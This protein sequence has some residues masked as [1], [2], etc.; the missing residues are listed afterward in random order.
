MCIMHVYNAYNIMHNHYGDITCKTCLRLEHIMLFLPI[1]L[2][3]NSS[4]F[5]LLFPYYHPI[6]LMNLFKKIESMHKI[7]DVTYNFRFFQLEYC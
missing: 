5:N 7:N 2:F 6:I 3:R 4:Y 1:V